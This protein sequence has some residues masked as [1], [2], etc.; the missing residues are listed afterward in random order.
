MPHGGW[1]AVHEDVTE[2]HKVE[3]HIVHLAHHDAL[4]GLPNRTLFRERLTEGLAALPT[5]GGSLALLCLDLDHFKSVNDTLG[6]PVGDEMLSVV[7]RRLEQAVGDAGT[8]ARLGGDEFAIL[9]SGL[10]GTPGGAECMARRIGKTL[11]EPLV[12]EGH[13]INTGM[14][15]G[16]AIALRDAWSGDQLMKCADLALYRAKAEGRATYRFYEADMSRSMEARRQLELD[17][18]EAL[19]AEEF[20]LVFQPQVDSTG[21]KLAGF[22]ALVRWTHAL[23]G[24]VPPNDFIPIAEE[25]GLIVPLGRWVLEAACRQAVTWATSVPVAINLSPVQFKDRQLVDTVRQVLAETGLAPGRLELEITEAVL[26]QNDDVTM[27]MLHDLRALG[28]RIAMDDFGVGYSSL[29]YLRR[30]R[31][32]KIKIDRSFIADLDRGTDNAAIVRA[33]AQLGSSLGIDTTAEGVETDEQLAIVRA[34]GCTHIQG[35]LVSPPR[36]AMDVA[37]LIDRLGA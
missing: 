8:I 35:Y 14:S 1:V 25:T 4:T 29:S 5:S 24:P 33:M 18:R 20:H 37:A 9:L 32:D 7:A 19:A 2:R 16:I 22:E 6:H 28:V 13:V 17:L 21:L 23:R 3:Q 15:M 31:F 30:F 34:C 27:T 12:V 26:L 36:G 10:D 11:S